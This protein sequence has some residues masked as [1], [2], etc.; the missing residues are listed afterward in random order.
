VYNKAAEGGGEMDVML[1]MR[2]A[3]FTDD[4]I[5]L[6]F[7]FSSSVCLQRL[8]RGL[9]NWTK[10][11]FRGRGTGSVFGGQGAFPGGGAGARQGGGTVADGLLKKG[12]C[13]L[14]SKAE[15]GGY[16][17]A[18]LTGWGGGACSQEPL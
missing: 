1:H 8:G 6:V 7:F 3:H 12:S 4:V 17:E 11:R 5:G 10:G 16:V 14:F 13:W 15:G 9:G 2:S 18:A